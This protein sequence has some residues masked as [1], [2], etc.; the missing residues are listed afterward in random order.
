MALSVS[1]SH[2]TNILESILRVLYL[3]LDTEEMKKRMM[4]GKEEDDIRDKDMRNE[5]I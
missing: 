1:N 4:G 3:I 5:N 2:L